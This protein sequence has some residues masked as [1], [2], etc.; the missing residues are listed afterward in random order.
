MSALGEVV[1]DL[2]PVL[3]PAEIARGAS[4]EVVRESKKYLCPE[5]LEKRAPGI[6][7][8][9]G[10]KRADALRRDD[11]NALGLAGKT[12]ELFV[13]RRRPLPSGSEMM[14][15]V[16]EEK[17][18]PEIPLRVSLNLWDAIQDGPLEVELHHDSQG[19]CQPGVH[20]CR[21]IE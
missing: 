3:P 1:A 20:D 18:L 6:A 21:K 7:R 10:L 17:H 5:G 4:G 19:L 11:R 15:F 8:Q 9:R 13:A 14:V 16:A 12:E 2:E